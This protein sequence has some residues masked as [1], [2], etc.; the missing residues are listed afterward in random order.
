MERN[1][2]SAEDARG[3]VVQKIWDIENLGHIIQGLK[4]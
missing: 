2:M 1:A 4:D 3:Q